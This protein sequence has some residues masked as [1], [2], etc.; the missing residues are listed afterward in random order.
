[1][2]PEDPS[3]A[4]AS[5]AAAPHPTRP[6]IVLILVDDMGYA[7]IGCF[8]SEIET[9]S[10]DGLA[11]QGLAFTQA[12]N[13][14]RCCPTRA[15]LL[16]G[17]YPHQA[18]VG[19]MV[20]DLGHRP[21]QGYLR[22]DCVTMAEVLRGAGYRTLMSGKWHVGGVFSR[23]ATSDWTLDD[24][25]RPLPVDRGFDE[26]YGTPAGAGS[27][28]NPKP[29]FRD[30][31]IIEPDFEDYY[32]TDAVSDHAVR[33]IEGAAATEAPFFLYVAYTAPHWPLHAPA[34]TVAKYEGRYAGG[35]DPL[36]EA[37]FENL[38][39]R[40]ILEARWPL[41]PRDGRA[42]DWAEVPHKAWEQR[43]MEVYAAQV[44]R[45]D[46]GVGR[47]LAAL[48]RRGIAADTLVLFLSDNGGCHEQLGE[49]QKDREW[50]TTRDGRPVRFGNRPDIMPG[51]AD[52]YQ[53]YG[54]AWAN[55]SNS[56]FRL[57]KHWTHEGGIATPLLAR[58]PRRIAPG[59]LCH[60]PCH[61]IDIMATC[62]DVAGAAYPEEFGGRPIQPMEG[63][64]LAP[65]FDAKTPRRERPI[66]F[67]HEGNR[68]VRDGRWKLVSRYR[69]SWR[70]PVEDL[71]PWE[72]YDMAADRTE[73]HDLAE[74]NRP[75]AEKLAAMYTDY[76][77]RTGVI[78]RPELLKGGRRQ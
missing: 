46:Q 70:D 59:G 39:G 40:G 62:V 10:L 19:D 45:M 43:R 78:P 20:G 6:N 1:M 56:P 50:P 31:R 3:R 74:A 49:G 4:S 71:G 66:F 54:P 17:L 53:S 25:T 16:T 52:T 58:W 26:W 64:G 29:L 11:S 47:V 68:A 55:A 14:A 51:P 73:T 65:A 2:P 27:Y 28:F 23:N 72:L 32:Y 61:V 12:Y 24:P 22:D 76:A 42:D 36:R 75:Q 69:G 13:C 15:S 5:D 37:R 57:F 48:E 9:P 18:G 35:W 38:K 60:A 77:R 41:S 44:D 63:E 34:E 7:D 67:E 21:Y 8:G 30:R 33:M